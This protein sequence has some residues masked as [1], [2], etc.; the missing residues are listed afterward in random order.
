MPPA[1]LTH[2]QSESDLTLVA[3]AKRRHA[4]MMMLDSASPSS[5]GDVPESP[6]SIAGAGAGSAPS[7]GMRK[8]T[9][10]SKALGA[11]SGQVNANTN[12]SLDSMMDVEEDGRERKRVARR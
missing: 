10:S 1:Q 4:V 7:G 6:L 9:R 2:S 8:R 3:G 5:I 11:L 12:A